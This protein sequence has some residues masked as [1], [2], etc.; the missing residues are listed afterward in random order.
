VAGKF[1]DELLGVGLRLFDVDIEL[2]ADPV[3]NDVTQGSAAVGRLK[4]G[5]CDLVQVKK[6]ESVEF[7]TIISPASARAA[8]AVLR[9]I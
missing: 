2:F 3:A 5:G 9:A 8:I 7:M 4:D 1:G 6:V